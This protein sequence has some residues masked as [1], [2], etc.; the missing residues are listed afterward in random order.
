MKNWDPLS[1]FKYLTGAPNNHLTLAI[2]V[3]CTASSLRESAGRPL[4]H[5]HEDGLAIYQDKVRLVTFMGYAHLLC[6]LADF[7][8]DTG[9]CAMCLRMRRSLMMS[10]LS[11][12]L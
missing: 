3:M 1:I 11:L 9:L 12:F 7:F 10:S 4:Y 6:F 5:D 8:L 2:L